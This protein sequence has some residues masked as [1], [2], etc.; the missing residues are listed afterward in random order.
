MFTCSILDHAFHQSSPHR[1][2]CSYDPVNEER[3]A[4]KNL[5]PKNKAFVEQCVAVIGVLLAGFQRLVSNTTCLKTDGL[6]GNSLHALID[7][8]NIRYRVSKHVFLRFVS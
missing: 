8:K 7:V 1:K 3:M 2:V 6:K 5:R 4:N